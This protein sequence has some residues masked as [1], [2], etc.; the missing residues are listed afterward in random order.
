MTTPITKDMKTIS[1]DGGQTV[2]QIIDDTAVHPEDI[3]STYNPLGTEPINGTAIAGA[4]STL[5]IPIVDQT[6]S[7]SSTNAQSGTAVASAL[8][9]LIDLIPD[10]DQTYSASSTNAQS[11]TAVASALVNVFPS[12]EGQSGKFLS[13]DGTVPVWET[14]SGGSLPSQSG[15]SGKFLSTDGTVASWE[16]APTAVV[17]STLSSTST[18]PVENGVITTAL[19]NKLDVNASNLS[20]TGQ[21]VFDGQWS[22]SFTTLVNSSAPPTTQS[23]QISLSEYLPN[24]TYDYL[25][26]FRVSISVSSTS[27]SK[28]AIAI[29]SDIFDNRLYLAQGY[30][31]NGSKVEVYYQYILPVGSGRYI[32]VL[33]YAYNTGTY[34][35]YAIGYRRIGTNS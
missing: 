19:N 18:N 33:P 9:S 5:D 28:E 23:V 22:R 15:N 31:I 8:D 20:S 7:A 26:Y 1:F 10:V 3:V 27:G 21:K 11:G 13:T 35:L 16:T 17:D 34:N 14:V 29:W 30:N 12:Q 2:Y 4:L 24:D 25:V 32:E 6:Y